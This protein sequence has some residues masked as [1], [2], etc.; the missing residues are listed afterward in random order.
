MSSCRIPRSVG[1]QEIVLFDEYIFSSPRPQTTSTPPLPTVILCSRITYMILTDMAM[2]HSRNLYTG[3][4]GTCQHI[5]HQHEAIDIMLLTCKLDTRMRYIFHRTLTHCQVIQ[6]CALYCIY[7]TNPPTI[8]LSAIGSTHL[9]LSTFRSR[10]IVENIPN[11][12]LL[13]A[14][15][16]VYTCFGNSYQY[17]ATH[18]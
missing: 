12:K 16:P 14:N 4:S 3:T 11:M 18:C 15:I 17:P 8:G 5:M 7:K 6:L 10:C 9:L 1:K 13:Q 2:N